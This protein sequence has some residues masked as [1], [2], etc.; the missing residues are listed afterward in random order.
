M[1][2]GRRYFLEG[3]KIGLTKLSRSE[4][5]EQYVGWLNDREVTRNLVSGTFPSSKQDVEA[6][7]ERANSPSRVTFAIYR[8]TAAGDE[9]VGNCKLDNIDWVSRKADFGI[10]I[11]EP[12][13]WGQGIATEATRLVTEYA[14]VRLNLERV[15]LG[16]VVDNA[17]AARIYEKLG[18][19]SEGRRVADQWIDGHYG[20][21]T[22]MSVRRDQWRSARMR[23]VAIIQARMSSTRLPGKVLMSLGGRPAL[24]VLVDRVKRA[25][26]LDEV[27][28]A[29]STDSSDGVLAEFCAAEKI[30]C[31]RGPL[32]DVLGRYH[33][34]AEVTGAD[35]IVRITADCPLMD[36]DVVDAIVQRF[37][38]EHEHIDFAS[39][40]DDRTFPNGLD[41]EV[42]SRSALNEAARVAGAED[43]EHV[44]DFIRRTRRK[45]TVALPVD[46]HALR[47]TL[48][49]EDDH[50][51][52][53]SIFDAL[54]TGDWRSDAL[55]RLLLARPELLWTEARQ[56]PD[57]EQREV[58]A[59]RLQRMLS[60]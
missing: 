38:D 26:S 33:L 58:F 50:R 56:A 53:A 51:V 37:R 1:S 42:F 25:T 32:R 20:D 13:A 31:V 57:K 54:G 27:V 18:Y 49:Y 29:T 15:S 35:V 3:E 2:V 30:R 60:G 19:V 17:A 9:H 10:M 14:F 23:V 7:I 39:N 12:S 59:A 44:T 47:Y 41:V 16:V 6:Y 22:N 40:A 8:K 24:G 45:V 52:I 46:L 5:T 21:V 11:G 34:A 28:V 55:Y 36:P 4:A 43:R 48:D